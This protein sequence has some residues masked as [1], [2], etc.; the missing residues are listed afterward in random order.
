MNKKLS[1]LTLLVSL[2]LS[3]IASG[4]EALR[5]YGP[6]GPLPVMREAAQVFGK[7]HS[8]KVD[9]TAGPTAEW[10]EKAKGLGSEKR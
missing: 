10:I 5:I 3:R 6:G 2:S 9:V 8:V 1:A 7:E 4:E